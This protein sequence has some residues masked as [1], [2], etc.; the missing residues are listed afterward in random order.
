MEQW[1]KTGELKGFSKPIVL[2]IFFLFWRELPWSKQIQFAV[3][4]FWV[5]VHVYPLNRRHKK[6]GD[7]VDGKVALCTCICISVRGSFSNPGRKK[8][9]F[10]SVLVFQGGM[11]AIFKWHLQSRSTWTQSAPVRPKWTTGKFLWWRKLNANHTKH[12]HSHTS[13]R[14]AHI[15]WGNKSTKLDTS[16]T[17]GGITNKHSRVNSR[18]LQQQQMQKTCGCGANHT[19]DSQ[20]PVMSCSFVSLLTKSCLSSLRPPKTSHPPSFTPVSLHLPQGFSSF[21]F[22]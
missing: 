12:S 11:K 1:W 6:E 9:C 22:A 17:P 19:G 20:S 15:V 3:F 4:S 14:C 18:A 10:L 5:C 7:E 13:I 21:H 8:V 2:N 16:C